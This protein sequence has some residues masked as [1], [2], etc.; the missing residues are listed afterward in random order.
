MKDLTNFKWSIFTLLYW[1]VYVGK[2]FFHCQLQ[3]T[4]R[5]H[6]LTCVSFVSLQ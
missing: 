5:H 6:H 3:R 4:Q 1:Y 2:G